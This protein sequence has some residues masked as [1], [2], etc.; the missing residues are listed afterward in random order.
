M[1]DIEGGYDFIIVLED[2]DDS[3]IPSSSYSDIMDYYSENPLRFTGPL[4][5]QDT[6]QLIIPNQR[7]ALVFFS[8]TSVGA[9][10]FSLTFNAIFSMLCKYSL[11]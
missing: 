10:G 6:P 3:D 7:F 8:D 11:L 2:F 1:M 9:N 5:D 4:E